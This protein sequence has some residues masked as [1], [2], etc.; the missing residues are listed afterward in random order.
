MA[1]KFMIDT[2]SLN[3]PK[4]VIMAA[5]TD[6]QDGPTPVAGVIYQCTDIRKELSSA[7]VLEAAVSHLNTHD[8]YTF[9][10]NY[11]PDSLLNT[12]GPTGVNI[13]DLYL[14]LRAK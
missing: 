5:G 8:S 6:G 3:D 13:M 11:A 7:S 10:S 9:W 12:N 14:V 2:L 4:I 1:L